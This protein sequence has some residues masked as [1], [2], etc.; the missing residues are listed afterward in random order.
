MV[1]S[2]RM[3]RIKESGIRAVQKRI[4]GK[5]DIISFAA[6]LPDPNLYPI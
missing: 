4:V 3:S 1:F 2:I 6:G 5:S